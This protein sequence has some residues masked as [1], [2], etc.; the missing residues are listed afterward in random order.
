MRN[1]VRV[2]VA[3]VAGWA[4]CLP[5]LAQDASPGAWRF[6]IEPYLMAPHMKGDTGIADLPTVSVNQSAS[7]ILDNLEMGAMLYAEADDGNS[8]IS[9][10]FIYMNLGS[11]VSIRPPVLQGRMD[12]SQIAF[13]L[14]WLK[15]LTPHFDLGASAVYNRIHADVGVTLALGEQSRTRS[16]GLTEDWIDPTIV[17]RWT[18][19]LGERWSV[20]LRGNLGGFGIGSELFWQLQA[21]AV[22]RSSPRTQWS[23]GYRIID[24]DYDRGQGLDRFVYDMATFGPVVKFGFRF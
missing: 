7:D 12:V 17:A 20:Q 15:H 9:T 21:N 3:V 4:A 16:A 23:F 14:A 1:A 8:T 24:I 18:R 10:D 6:L 2:Y 11:D 5:V 19:P 22:W 13:E